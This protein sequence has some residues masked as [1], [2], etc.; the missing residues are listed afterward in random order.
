MA[1]TA[2]LILKIARD[3]NTSAYDWTY[4]KTIGIFHFYLGCQKQPCCRP[5]SL[6]KHAFNSALHSLA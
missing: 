1:I 3:K 4:H 5:T 6:K 2:W